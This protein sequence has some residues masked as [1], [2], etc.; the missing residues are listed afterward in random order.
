MTSA[1]CSRRPYWRLGHRVRCC[2]PE[3]LMVAR[4]LN[5]TT[6]TPDSWL[7]QK[8]SRWSRRRYPPSYAPCMASSTLLCA[9]SSAAVESACR[10][11]APSFPASAGR[12]VFAL[13]DPQFSGGRRIYEGRS[14]GSCQG[15]EFLAVKHLGAWAFRDNKGTFAG[16]H[17]FGAYG[18]NKQ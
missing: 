12:R 15:A 18:P 3:S 17:M 11:A 14:I 9:R 16:R 5:L 4:S 1:F 6:K 7:S 10:V 2:R 8:R 13:D